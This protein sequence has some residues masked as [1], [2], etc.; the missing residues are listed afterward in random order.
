M[1]TKTVCLV[2]HLDSALAGRV[3]AAWHSIGGTC[4]HRQ[5]A[6][7]LPVGEIVSWHDDLEHVPKT[8]A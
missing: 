6:M 3:A 5:Y 2:Q 1:R 7:P 8:V 4:R